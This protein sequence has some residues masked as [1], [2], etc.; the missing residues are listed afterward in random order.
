M[1]KGKKPASGVNYEKMDPYA[2]DVTSGPGGSTMKED[3]PPPAPPAPPVRKP[4]TPTVRKAM[5]GKVGRGCG[6][7]MRGGG[8]VMMGSK[9]K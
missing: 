7:A 8:C 4:S 2:G 5:G 6:V 9:K 3:I 1:A